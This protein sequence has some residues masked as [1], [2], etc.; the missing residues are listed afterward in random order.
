MWLSRT[1]LRLLVGV[2]IVVVLAIPGRVRAACSV[3]GSGGP[4]SCSSGTCNESC[5]TLYD[6]GA[7]GIT[8][9]SCDT[10]CTSVDAYNNCV[11]EYSC[12]W[13]QYECDGSSCGGTGSGGGVEAYDY[14]VCSGGQ[15][16]A[17]ASP[18]QYLAGGGTMTTS[19]AGAQCTFKATCGNSY[20]PSAFFPNDCAG[21]DTAN[22]GVCQTNCGCCDAGQELVDTGGGNYACQ[23]V[24]GLNAPR[25]TVNRSAVETPFFPL[26]SFP[27]Q[28]YNTPRKQSV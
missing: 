22:R 4:T 28:L 26:S 2:G 23:A 5:H 15:V 24:C 18:A 20:F 25:V 14:P 19:E 3:T 17:C 13:N 8:F 6:G 16:L 27:I 7:A 21:E 10:Y 11:W 1:V 12:Y 9:Y